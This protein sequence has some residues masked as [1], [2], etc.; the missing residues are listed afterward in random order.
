MRNSYHIRRHGSI[1][2]FACATLMIAL[3]DRER[4]Q[5][6]HMWAYKDFEERAQRRARLMA[7]PRWIAFAGKRWPLVDRPQN[8]TL[9]PMAFSPLPAGERA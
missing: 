6:V 4:S 1:V 7:D 2:A 9:I 3:S 5:I 8:K